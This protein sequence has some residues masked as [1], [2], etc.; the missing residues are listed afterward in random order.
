MVRVGVFDRKQGLGR[1]MWWHTSTRSAY[2]W[3]E[4]QK[5]GWQAYLDGATDRAHVTVYGVKVSVCGFSVCSCGIK[6]GLGASMWVN[7]DLAISLPGGDKSQPCWCVSHSVITSSCHGCLRMQASGNLHCRSFTW[8][9]AKKTL[10]YTAQCQ[11]EAVCHQIKRC[12]GIEFSWKVFT[13]VDLLPVTPACT[14]EFSKLTRTRLISNW[15]WSKSCD[16]DVSKGNP[17]LL[18]VWK[19]SLDVIIASAPF[20]AVK[21]VLSVAQIMRNMTLWCNVISSNPCRMNC[22]CR[23]LLN[24]CAEIAISLYQSC[25]IIVH[26]PT[27]WIDSDF[28]P[29]HALKAQ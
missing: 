8:H 16:P 26:F 7:C 13:S 15:I 5:D 28:L 11:F 9:K 21:F 24:I 19:L 12:R 22:T 29:W 1:G 25:A 10:F 17:W 20:E 27:T 4:K 2:M 18:A 3:S 6:P 14:A 23:H